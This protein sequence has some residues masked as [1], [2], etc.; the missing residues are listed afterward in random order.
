VASGQPAT[1]QVFAD[2]TAQTPLAE[3]TVEEPG[4]TTSAV[5]DGETLFCG[6]EPAP[7]ESA[8]ISLC[9]EISEF[10]FIFIEGQGPTVD[11]L[12]DP[13]TCSIVQVPAG[14]PVTFVAYLGDGEVGRCTLDDPLD[15]DLVLWDGELAC[16]PGGALPLSAT[17]ASGHGPALEPIPDPQFSRGNGRTKQPDPLDEALRELSK[18]S[19]SAR[20]DVRRQLQEVLHAANPF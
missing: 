1:F 18:L 11:D 17:G 15:G 20:Q 14:E 6:N 13:G 3:C 9:N 2:E 19:R 8:S 4:A 5:W 12:V 16:I 10:L 7:S